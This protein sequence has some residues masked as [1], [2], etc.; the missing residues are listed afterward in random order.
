MIPVW[1]LGSHPL[2]DDQHLIDIITDDDRYTHATEA[3]DAP[4]GAVV[5]CPARY[6][7]PDDINALIAPLPWVVLILTSDEESTFDA[8]KVEHPN[9]RLWVM[10]PR[11]DHV[12]PPGT[13]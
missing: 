12:Y 10:T 2:C 6:H 9:M 1:W 8:M 7:T 13:R 4:G 3:P 5:V 11:P